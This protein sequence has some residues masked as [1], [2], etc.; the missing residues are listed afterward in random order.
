MFKCVILLKQEPYYIMASDEN[1]S[2]DICSKYKENIIGIVCSEKEIIFKK[3]KETV[4]FII[5][6]IK[7]I[8][9][10]MIGDEQNVQIYR[11]IFNKS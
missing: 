8:E 9:E 2:K 6:E 7:M 5:P 4:E 3:V 11:E 10:I 1:E